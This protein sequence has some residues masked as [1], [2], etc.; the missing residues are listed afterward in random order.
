[1]VIFAWLF[2]MG[3]QI[4]LLLGMAHGAIGRHAWE[5][6]IDKYGYYS[7]VRMRTHSA[8]DVPLTTETGHSCGT[9]VLRN[10]DSS[11]QVLPRPVLPTSQSQQ[12]LPSLCL[13]H[14]GSDSGGLHLHLLQLTLCLQ[15]HCWKLGS[16]TF[17]RRSMPQPWR[18]LHFSS[19]HRHCD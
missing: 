12:N 5:I 1:M 18:H 9:T 4:C 11:S 8:F 13:V 6:S 2:C 17:W 14:S 15:A 16:E 19:G 10:R 3:A 7:R